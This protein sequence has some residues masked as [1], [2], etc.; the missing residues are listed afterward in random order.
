MRRPLRGERARQV[1]DAA[2]RGAVR[3]A[4]RSAHQPGLRGDVDDLALRRSIIPRA[5]AWVRKNSPFR[6]VSRIRSQS[7]SVTSSA[8][9]SRFVPGVVHEHVDPPER[10]EH[11]LHERRIEAMS[12]TSSGKHSTR[13]PP[14]ARSP[15]PPPPAPPRSGSPAPAPPPSPPRSS[16]IA[17]PIPRPAPVTTIT[18]PRQS[19][20]ANPAIMLLPAVARRTGFLSADERR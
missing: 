20:P 19:N 8:G 9:F 10:R 4:Q 5:T 12:V 6:L 15:P 2:L 3:R 17:F 1:H 16:A 13:C 11:P 18:L 7:S 14:A